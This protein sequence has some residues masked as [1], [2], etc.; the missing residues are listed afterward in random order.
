[1]KPLS[2]A[3]IV[4]I[5]E[6]GQRMRPVER[7]LLILSAADAERKPIPI[8]R[9]DAMLLGIRGGVFGDS[10]DCFATCPGCGE[11]VQF[12]LSAREL[13]MPGHEAA[14]PLEVA[15]GSY[16]IR[17]KLPDSSD[18]LAAAASGDVGTARRLLMARCVLRA[19]MDGEPVTAE[20]L[21][22]DAVGALCSAILEQD[23]GSEIL[24]DLSCASCGRQWQALFDIVPFLWREF[25]A[26]ARRL[27]YEV[28]VLAAAY[29]WSE[30]DI[31]AMSAARRRNYLEMI[32]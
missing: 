23:P 26:E 28:H 15:F 19:T 14:T 6:L 27:L 12:A 11:R 24:L 1:M 4:R 20:G 3:D 7:A 8:G 25:S 29:G 17:F 18:Q 10:M 21:P 32:G 2:A 13:A 31:F 22:E 9:R 30:Y 5:W 16:L